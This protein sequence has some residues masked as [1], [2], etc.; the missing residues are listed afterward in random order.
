MLRVLRAG[1]HTPSPPAMQGM[2]E[3]IQKNGMGAMMKYWNDPQMLA[4]LGQKIGDVP[5]AA[6]AAAPAEPEISDLLD[7]ARCAPPGA[8]PACM[9]GQY[10]M[11]IRGW[12]ALL[13][14]R[15]HV[16]DVD[17][18][19][20]CARLPAA[21]VG[22][23][24]VP[25]SSLGRSEALTVAIAHDEYVCMSDSHVRGPIVNFGTEGQQGARALVAPTAGSAPV[26][27]SSGG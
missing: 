6:P 23:S 4:K 5:Q 13:A 20:P 18:C 22:V 21:E 8:V 1:V 25:A 10:H 27:P 11:Q 3:D 17:R 12:H 9:Q 14:A 15:P 19:G 7:A 16:L 26:T 24:G 2:F